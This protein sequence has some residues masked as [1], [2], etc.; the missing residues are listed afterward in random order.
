[1]AQPWLVDLL[2][3]QI[4]RGGLKG[5]DLGNMEMIMYNI[6]Q[7]PVFAASQNCRRLYQQWF[8]SPNS[9]SKITRKPFYQRLQVPAYAARYGDLLLNGA[10]ALSPE[11]KPAIHRF[12]NWL[13]AWAPE[14]RQTITPYADKLKNHLGFFD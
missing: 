12:L 5:F 10:I 4:N 11:T 14:T 9:F 1:M 2:E 3:T 13:D 6:S 7:N 8:R